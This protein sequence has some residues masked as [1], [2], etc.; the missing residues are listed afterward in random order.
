ML[1]E[2]SKCI[3]AQY[4]WVCLCANL[5][6]ILLL[7]PSIWPNCTHS[8]THTHIPTL[9]RHEKRFETLQWRYWIIWKRENSPNFEVSSSLHICVASMAKTMKRTRK[10]IVMYNDDCWWGVSFEWRFALQSKFEDD[11]WT[12]DRKKKTVCIQVTSSGRIFCEH[13]ATKSALDNKA[14][15]LQCFCP[16]GKHGKGLIW[17]ANEKDG[18]R[19]SPIQMIQRQKLI[20]CTE[21]SV[22]SQESLT[23]I[24]LDTLRNSERKMCCDGIPLFC[25]FFICV[26]KSR[27]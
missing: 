17:R 10:W 12:E 21:I 7:L 1:D 15:N 23:R 25:H 19:V 11:D 3:R 27:C 14:M 22:N 13:N 5:K 6:A 24:Y 18:L 8:P 9:T 20:N 26:L 2:S 16:P 4:L